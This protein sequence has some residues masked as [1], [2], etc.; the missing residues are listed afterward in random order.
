MCVERFALHDSARV[1]CAEPLLEK[2]KKIV[3]GE[4]EA[5]AMPAGIEEGAAAKKAEAKPAGD[6]DKV[7]VRPSTHIV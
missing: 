4:E 3:T 6:G 7:R 1:G 2:R 5:P